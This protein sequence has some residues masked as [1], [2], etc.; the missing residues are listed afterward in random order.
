MKKLR[1]LSKEEIIEFTES[2]NTVLKDLDWECNINAGGCAFVSY[3]LAKNLEKFNLKYKVVLAHSNCRYK[4]NIKECFS[5]NIGCS[6]VYIKI[7]GIEV[8]NFKYYGKEIEIIAKSEELKNYYV[9]TLKNCSWNPT[10]DIRDAAYI[11]KTI[12]KVFNEKL[13]NLY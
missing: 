9:R 12:S 4:K 3:I 6:H 1:S 7:K 13:H 5:N 8:N 10:F 11:K 2:L